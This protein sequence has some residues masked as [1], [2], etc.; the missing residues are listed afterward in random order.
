MQIP[1]NIKYIV[2]LKVASVAILAFAKDRVESKFTYT[3]DTGRWAQFK[4]K[5]KRAVRKK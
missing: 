2:V 1:T 5:V 4:V 3:P